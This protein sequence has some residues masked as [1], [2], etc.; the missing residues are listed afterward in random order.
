[1]KYKMTLGN[2]VCKMLK[3]SEIKFWIENEIGK[4]DNKSVK[5]EEWCNNACIGDIY[6]DEF[7]HIEVTD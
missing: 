1:M 3:P 7:I 4:H 5:A 6:D 2:F